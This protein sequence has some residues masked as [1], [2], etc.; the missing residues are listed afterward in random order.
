MNFIKKFTHHYFGVP[1][2]YSILTHWPSEPS[3][4]HLMPPMLL[5]DLQSLIPVDMLTLGS[6]IVPLCW[7]EVIDVSMLESSSGSD[8]TTFISL[9]LKHNTDNMYVR[10]RL[11]P[12]SLSEDFQ[13]EEFQNLVFIESCS[14][15]EF[16]IHT[17]LPKAGKF[18]LNVYLQNTPIPDKLHLSYIINSTVEKGSRV[19]YPFIFP[20]AAKA[21]KFK[22]LYWNKNRKSYDCVHSGENTLP[23][24]FEADKN[25][26]FYHCIVQ[27]KVDTLNTNQPSSILLYNTM[28][29]MDKKRLFQLMAVFPSDGWWTIHLSAAKLSEDDDTVS[30][31]TTLLTYKVYVENGK[32]EKSYP[33]VLKPNSVFFGSDPIKTPHSS[34][35]KL[36]FA[37]HNDHDLVNYV[38]CNQEAGESLEGYST[39]DCIDTVDDGKYKSYQLK[40]V[41]PKPDTWFVH[42]FSRRNS[43]GMYTATFKL[44]LEITEALHNKTLLQ[45]IDETRKHCGISFVDSG[46]ITFEDDGKPFS[47]SF[48]APASGIDFLHSLKLQD[49]ENAVDYRT[50]FVA[51]D[52][53]GNTEQSE[54]SLTVLFPERGNWRI[55]SYALNSKMGDNDYSLVTEI[56]LYVSNPVPALCYP[57]I[58]PAFKDLGMKI[59]EVDALIQATCTTGEFKLSFQ[60]P[61]HT[62]F[63]C[64]LDNLE[65]NNPSQQAYVHSMPDSQERI[66]HMVFPNL[67]DWKVALFAKQRSQNESKREEYVQ[68]MQLSLN[69]TVCKAG[70]SFP[71]IFEGFYKF[72]I[73]LAAEDIPLPS[74]LNVGE[75]LQHLLL[76]FY[77]PEGVKFLHYG[78]FTDSD[79]EKNL[80]KSGVRERKMTTMMSNPDTGLHQVQIEVNKIGQWTLYLFAESLPNSDTEWTPI[81]QYQFHAVQCIK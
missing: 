34:P 70:L 8:P 69:N 75:G 64:N 14:E 78:S 51:H 44:K 26:T 54:Y 74:V 52:K 68:I 81:L 13:E 33:H 49:D 19:G 24:V 20:T 5:Q 22:P 4:Q 36:L 3:Q 55:E 23:I 63:L 56:K 2:Q 17:V 73:H 72:N 47:F 65:A 38:T 21:F 18:V 9:R 35:L 12:A 30:G 42:V 45:S 10:A 66:L 6:G 15:N 62:H 57:K 58:W 67:G 27:G 80:E 29:V 31:Y 59:R 79:D 76:K 40:A 71:Q 28:L 77:S 48:T 46:I 7:S 37:M 1:P 39:V 61:E 25:T 60:A 43:N 16:H 11:L 41:F 50:H 32:P 53:K